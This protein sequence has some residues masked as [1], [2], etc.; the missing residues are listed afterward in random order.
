[1]SRLLSLAG[2]FLLIASVCSTSLYEE[3]VRI[4]KELFN[5]DSDYLKSVRPPGEPT[6]V[7][8]NMYVRNIFAVD[9]EHHT[10]KVQLTFRQEWTDTRLHFTSD[11]KDL[12]YIPHH[13]VKDIWSPDLFFTDEVHSEDHDILAENNL[14]RIQP[15]GHIVYSTRVT[16]ELFCRDDFTKTHVVCP[17]R[18]A[19]Y[20]Y[21]A[22]EIDI[23]W[24]SEDPVQVKDNILIPGGYSFEG[25]TTNDCDS[26]TKMGTFSCINADFKFGHSV[27]HA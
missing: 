22:E 18:I 2:C 15:D 11:L 13:R 8:V 17:I 24:T 20:G 23:K 1:M 26:K 4:V 14:V 25:V 6:N 19:S 12:K 5:K 3:E 10:W 27:C 9:P 16:L 21:T 7:T